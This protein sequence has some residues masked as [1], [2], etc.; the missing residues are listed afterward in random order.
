MARKFITT[1]IYFFKLGNA[2]LLHCRNDKQNKFV[3]DKK[4]TPFGEYKKVVK[5]KTFCSVH[6]SAR[7]CSDGVSRSETNY[8]KL[9]FFF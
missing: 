6:V 4:Q 8:L 3:K 5:V 9:Y 2:A 7:K 1:E